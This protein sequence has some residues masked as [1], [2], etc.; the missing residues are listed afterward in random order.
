MPKHARTTI[1]VPP[2][3]K[4]RMEAVE[5]SVNWSAIACQAFEQKLA[6]ITKRRGA[7]DMKEVVARLRASKERV[8]NELYRRG[9]EVGKA[10][11]M[12]HAEADELARLSEFYRE[13]ESSS[14]G[15]DG[16][17]AL[18]ESASAYGNGERIAF[19]IL[20]EDYDG[21][22]TA[23]EEFWDRATEITRDRWRQEGELI[24]RF[25]VQGF[26]DGALQIWS[27]V[28]DEI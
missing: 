17:F 26:A 25:F 11:A 12:N 15:W 21:V 7:R 6:Q 8:G 28:E 4:A 14:W 24:D 18:P 19:A 3:L 22:R 9:I 2:D 23:A 13:C 20:G 10:W 1:T 16:F 27:Q 5:E